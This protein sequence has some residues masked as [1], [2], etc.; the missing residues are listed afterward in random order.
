MPRARVFDP[1]RYRLCRLLQCQS[2]AILGLLQFK[3]SLGIVCRASYRS[4]EPDQ[5]PVTH[6]GARNKG[7]TEKEIFGSGLASLLLE[8]QPSLRPI[9]CAL[10]LSP[11]QHRSIKLSHT[12][13]AFHR[14]KAVLRILTDTGDHFS[15]PHPDPPRPPDPHALHAPRSPL[16]LIARAPHMPPRERH[17]LKPKRVLG[18]LSTSRECQSRIMR[19]W[20]LERDQRDASADQVKWSQS[21]RKRGFGWS[22]VHR[23]RAILC[24][25]SVLFHDVLH[26][27]DSNLSRGPL[28]SG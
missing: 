2:S 3:Q 17:A 21:F 14:Q 25:R 10:F 8:V 5:R 4:E 15:C 27:N 9:P 12:G 6:L 20:K 24:F 18:K 22:F 16:P 26:F 11:A 13:R 19:Y 28:M 23:A 7:V 1:S